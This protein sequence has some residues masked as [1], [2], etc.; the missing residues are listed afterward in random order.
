MLNFAPYSTSLDMSISLLNFAQ[1]TIAPDTSMVHIAAGLRC[2]ILGVYGAF[3]GEIRMSTYPNADWVEPPGGDTSI[4]KYGGKNCYTHGQVCPAAKP[5][6]C[7]ACYSRI[8]SE[9]FYEKVNK[10]LEI[11]KDFKHDK[12]IEN[13]EDTSKDAKRSSAQ[14][15]NGYD[16]KTSG[17]DGVMS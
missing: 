1:L 5:G 16:E 10:L 13:G 6:Q 3:P 11:R 12:E 4:C 2:P 8:D 9:I 14:D 15:A 17:G 7:A